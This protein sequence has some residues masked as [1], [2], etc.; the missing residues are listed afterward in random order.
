[1]LYIIPIMSGDCCDV[2]A[3]RVQCPS[4]KRSNG[5]QRPSLLG[6]ATSGRIEKK[7]QRLGASLV[8]L[9]ESGSSMNKVHCMAC[10][11]SRETRLRC[12]ER[13]TLLHDSPQAAFFSFRRADR[14]GGPAGQTP[15][16][17][18]NYRHDRISALAA[19]RACLR[20]TEANRAATVRE[21]FFARLTKTASLR[22]RL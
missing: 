5:T 11:S 18:Y 22:A 8:F 13:L 6:S 20:S 19:L 4:A 10:K 15:M 21:R 9:E 16:V 3:G 14:Q 17:H 2:R 12:G 7:T 1:M